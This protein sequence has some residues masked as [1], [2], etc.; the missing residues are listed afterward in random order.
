MKNLLKEGDVIKLENGMKVYGKIPAMFVYSNKPLSD[1]LTNHE[2]KIGERHFNRTH[3]ES[4]KK[5][6]V[7][8][9]IHSFDFRLGHKMSDATATKFID[10]ILPNP[11]PKEFVL[12]GGEF[13]VIKTSYEGGGMAMFNDYYPDGHRVFCKRLKDGKYD[14]DGDEVNFYQSSG[15][16]AM[17]LPD[18]IQA[19]RTMKSSFV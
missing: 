9:I 13:V 17:I 4:D 18:E 15:F 8:D 2:I 11:T 6:L 1:E 10:A 12:E 7:K 19:I 16:T 5:S 3:I 14:E